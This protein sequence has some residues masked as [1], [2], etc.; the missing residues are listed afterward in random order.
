MVKY[1]PEEKT[2]IAI[3]EPNPI[4]REYLLALVGGA[5]GVTLSDACSSLGAALPDLEQSPPDLVIVDI[6]ADNGLVTTWLKQM[7]TSLPD[8]AVLVL[9]AERNREH[10]FEA[11][12]AGVSGWLEKPCT[13]DQVLH[14]IAMLQHGGAVLSSSVA[15]KILQY[16]QA[17]GHS[18]SH[19]SQREREILSLV[20]E[21]LQAGEIAERLD[22]SPSVVR[23]NVRTILL[24]L[25]ANSRAEA[26]AKY[27]NPPA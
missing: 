24:K 17:R 7:H 22:L 11:L 21:G 12:E 16:F 8:T 4:E 15:R 14:A 3:I 25:K 18:V 26:V 20:G 13:A 6:D 1:C 10:L 23:T 27:L 19:L 9:S 2:R 5:P